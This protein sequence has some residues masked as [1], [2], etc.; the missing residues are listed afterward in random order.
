MNQDTLKCRDFAE[1]LISITE[2]V[3]K[4]SASK[5]LPALSIFELLRPSFAQVLGKLG[6]SA[7]LSRALATANVNV[8]CLREVRV[9]PDGSLEGLGELE[10]KVDR[11]EIAEGQVVLLAEFFGLLVGLIGEQLVLQLVHQAMPK[12]SSDHLYFRE[13]NEHEKKYRG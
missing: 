11:K 13:G 5:T 1:R 7:V 2:I 6:F 3:T 8:V 10:A 4:S 9:K 12:V